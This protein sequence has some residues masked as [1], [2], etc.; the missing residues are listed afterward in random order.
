MY[1]LYII[2]SINCKKTYTGISGN[3]HRRLSQHNSD[4]NYSTRF[5]NDWDIIYQKECVNRKE[6]RTLEKHFKNAS[7]RKEIKII[8]ERYLNKKSI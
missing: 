4:Y 6:A 2:Y 8:L 5:C 3:T 7:G 1:Y